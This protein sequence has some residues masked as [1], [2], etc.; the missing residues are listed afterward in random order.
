MNTISPARTATLS[1]HA[2]AIRIAA[3]Q[4]NAIN[5][6]QLRSLGLTSRWVNGNVASGFLW[7]VD[8]RVYVIGLA[9][10]H[11]PPDTVAMIGILR[12]D[13]RAALGMESS[14]ERQGLWS[15]GT[16]D[17][18]VVTTS[19]SSQALHDLATDVTLHSHR[20]ST[21]EQSDVID[22]RGLPSTTA[23]RTIPELGLTLGP[24]QIAHVIWNAI[25]AE[26]LAV[27]ELDARLKNLQ[28]T[29]WTA[30]AREAVDLVMAGSCGTKSLSEDELLRIVELAGSPMP[31][32]NVL[33]SAGLPGVRLD[34][35]WPERRVVFELDGRHHA[36]LPGVAA[37]D[38]SVRAA[39]KRDGWTVL[40]SHY[41]RVWNDPIGIANRI[42]RAVG[43]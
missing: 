14:M 36:A 15:R 24:H 34:F 12:A 6:T 28:R 26:C 23:L 41:N 42:A 29:P 39:L 37:S 11:L 18:H 2:R 17:I 3:A 43:R 31:L 4:H 27:Q 19:R 1:R 22:V 40:T 35:V 20:V 5:T 10:G 32:V 8:P 16:S 25:Y 9:P 30:S 13:G 38:A 7:R 33:G 21:L